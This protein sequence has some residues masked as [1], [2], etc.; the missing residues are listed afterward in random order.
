[1]EYLQSAVVVRFRPI[2]P[3]SLY[4]WLERSS[5]NGEP[6]RL[7]VFAAIPFEGEQARE[8]L[9]RLLGAATQAGINRELNRTFYSCSQASHLFD[10][11]FTLEKDGSEGE[12]D[13][14]YSVPFALP[15]SITRVI[16]FSTLFKE[17]RD[18]E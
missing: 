6:P 8:V 14:H 15:I 3:S 18:D 13:E 16:H 5:R 17:R 2:N 4:K 10:Q 9:W 12:L 1:M 11:G 7:S